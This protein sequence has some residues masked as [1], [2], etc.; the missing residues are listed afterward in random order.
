MEISIRL[1][2]KD[3]KGKDTIIAESAKLNNGKPIPVQIHPAQK[4][5]WQA[6]LA[7]LTAGDSA[8]I[9]IPVDSIIKQVKQLPPF[10]KAGD[11]M[12]YEV[13]VF[14]IKSQDDYKKEMQDKQSQ[15]AQ[16]DDKAIQDYLAKNNIKA[17]KTASGLYYSI[18]SEGT[19][20]KITKGQTVNMMYTGKLI[21]GKVF[22]SNVDTA[23][24]HNQPLS[25]KVGFGGVIP[26][27]DE[28]VSLLKNHGK[29]TLYI[30]SPLGYGE[31]ATPTIPANS[32]LIFDISVVD[33]KSES[34]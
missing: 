26:G 27:M 31:R 34:K 19:G 29:A 21:D 17:E 24:K 14:D 30:P 4:N 25:F 22:D 16:T 6:P 33:V 12:E 9:H 28:G 18:S 7:V 23:F 32:V 3:N 20:E 2:I 11:I 8:I 10:M 13:K 1:K 5:D 15:Q